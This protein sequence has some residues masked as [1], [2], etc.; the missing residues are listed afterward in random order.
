PAAEGGGPQTSPTG[1]V[2][3]PGVPPRQSAQSRAATLAIA[4]G[5]YQT[6]LQEARA[7]LA[8]DSTNPIHYYLAGEASAG[9]GEFEAA[10]SLWQMAERMYPAYGLEIEPTREQ[11][12]AQEFNRGVE[13]YNA[14]NMA[15]AADAWTNAHFIYKLRPEAAQNLAVLLAQEG[16][17]PEA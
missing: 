17:Y 11:F 7:G 1:R 8:A 14:G 3:E 10:D 6:A 15:E 13:A 16:R 5:D 12:W 9:V 4:T 2:Y